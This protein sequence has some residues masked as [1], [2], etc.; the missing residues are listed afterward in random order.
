[1]G[2]VSLCGGD[3]WCESCL[4]RIADG[5]GNHPTQSEKDF[6]GDDELAAGFRLACQVVPRTDM[7]IDV[8]P[9]SLSA[10]QRLQV[11]GRDFD[12]SLAPTVQ[13]VDYF[14]RRK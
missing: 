7:R 11:E 14:R 8:P 5:E 13:V 1:M 9:E 4:V 3:G 2:L 10:P 6:L 12:I